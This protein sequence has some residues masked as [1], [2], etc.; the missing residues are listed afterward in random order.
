[1]LFAASHEFGDDAERTSRAARAMSA[2]WGGPEE[3]GRGVKLTRL[4]QLGR[5]NYARRS[6]CS[7][8]PQNLPVTL[9]T[10]VVLSVA[11]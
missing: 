2:I 10:T 7:L 1:M 11:L 5:L 4:T 6:R 8:R 9:K 3:E